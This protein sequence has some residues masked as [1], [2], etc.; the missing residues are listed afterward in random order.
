MGYRHFNTFSGDMI[1]AILSATQ[2]K[3][4]LEEN[5]LEN[6]KETGAYIKPKFQE[7]SEKYPAHMANV[8]G[9][10]CY[11]SFDVPSGAA[12]RDR[13]VPLMRAEGVNFG[14]CGTHSMRLRPNLYFGKKHADIL[15][16]ALEK[17]IK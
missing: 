10:G 15:L 13:L 9:L 5:L 1:R 12:N 16:S 11:L 14:V 8:R 7:M 6:V 4:I 2:N 3:V 17:S